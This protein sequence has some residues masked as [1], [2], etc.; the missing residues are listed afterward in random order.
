MM[1]K[2][3]AALILGA[4][5]VGAGPAGAA[6]GGMSGSSSDFPEMPRGPSPED[7]Q[8]NYNAGVA[9]VTAQ[10]WKTAVRKFSF[11]TEN[12]PD[13]ADAWNY[14]AYSSRKGGNPKKSEVAYKRALKIDPTHPRANEY[15]GE[16][17]LELNRIPEAEQRLAVLQTCCASNPVTAELAGL[18]A[19]A[20]AGKPTSRLKPSLGY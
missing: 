7:I 5:L 16:L 17:L 11:V 19:D 8:A 18:I 10:D 20:K 1:R 12:S 2:S 14:L 3:V 13:M 9:A 4:T 6:G 15:Y